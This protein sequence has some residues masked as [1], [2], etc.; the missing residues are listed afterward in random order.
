MDYGF[1][2]VDLSKGAA[3]QQDAKGLEQT[4]IGDTEFSPRGDLVLVGDADGF[5]RIYDPRHLGR[6]KRVVKAHEGFLEN[7]AFSPDGKRVLTAG[8]DQT[9]RLWDARDWHLIR[10]LQSGEG[11][12]AAAEYSPD[13]R[14]IATAG[15]D[16]SIRVW[17]ADSGSLVGI[18]TPHADFINSLQFSPDGRSLLSGSDDG[19]V[20]I[21]PCPTCVPTD[22]LSKL[23]AAR[24]T[25]R[26]TPEERRTHLGD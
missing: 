6:A 9:A 23:A 11:S 8:E 13:G 2:V 17:N 20:K 7:I 26:L 24:S 10:V 1:S 15:S 19:S 12:V 21:T 25:R 4:Q 18:E 22:E 16:R 14:M 5:L 3:G